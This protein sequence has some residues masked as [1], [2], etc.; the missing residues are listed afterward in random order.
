[1]NPKFEGLISL[2]DA[3]VK[4]NKDESTLR[5]NIKNKKFIEGEDCIK[6]GTT[7]VFD[8]TAL[9]REYKRDIPYL[10]LSILGKID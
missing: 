5:R 9:E 4:F 7:W 1:M 2:K 10:N 6:F 8:I 3:A